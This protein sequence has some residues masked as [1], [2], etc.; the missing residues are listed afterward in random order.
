MVRIEEKEMEGR[1]EREGM[2]VWVS[3]IERVSVGKHQRAVIYKLRHSYWSYHSYQRQRLRS[4]RFSGET[5]K[6]RHRPCLFGRQEN[7]PVRRPNTGTVSPPP[8]EDLH[9]GRAETKCV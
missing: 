5:L 7:A 3:W 4:P 9:A 2:K 6:R 8:T 1:K